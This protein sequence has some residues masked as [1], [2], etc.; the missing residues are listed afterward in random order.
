MSSHYTLT[1]QDMEI[2]HAALWNCYGYPPVREVITVQ[3]ETHPNYGSKDRPLRFVR[4]TAIPERFHKPISEMA[5]C[6]ACPCIDDLR[7]TYYVHDMARWL[8]AVGVQAEF[9]EA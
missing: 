9:V 1:E 5:I 6:C 7:N 3:I 4:L 8:R 2:A